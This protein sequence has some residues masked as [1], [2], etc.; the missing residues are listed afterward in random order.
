MDKFNFLDLPLIEHIKKLFPL[1][2]SITGDGLRETLGYFEK[3]NK[4]FKR[5]KFATGEKVLGWEIPKEWNIKDAYLEHIDTEKRFAEFSKSN[6]HLVGYSEPMN[7][8]ISYEELLK[9][10]H[11]LKTQPDLVPYVTSYY[12]KN[13]GFCLGE[14]T[15]NSL[16]KGDYRV[17]IDST[18]K[19]GCLDLSHAILRGKDDQELFFSSYVCH[20]SMA[21][22]E[23]SGPVLLNAIINYVK[24]TYPSN[25]YTY[26]FVMVPETIGSIAYISKYREDLKNKTICGFNLTCVGDE[27]AYSFVQTPYKDSLADVVMNSILIDK[28]NVKVYSFLNR[29]SDERQYCSPGLRLPVCTFS[30]SKFGEYPE[31]HTSADNL[32]LVTENGMQESFEVFKTI[33]DAFELGIY[34]IVNCYGEPQLGKLGLYPNLSVKSNRNA[35]NKRMDILAYCDGRRSL[36]EI[37]EIININLREI[38]NECKILNNAG[39]I[40]LS[41]NKLKDV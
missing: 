30:R 36:F 33:I 6:L 24:N 12:S 39:L 15:K 11:S 17:F 1:C 5:I 13:W 31:Y 19:D 21:N 26:R 3:F 38:V 29:G 18:L 20:P 32:N 2:R 35:V 40:R 28:K 10:I 22:N 7:K 25:F 4:E 9:K 14:K 27:R 34:P 41:R 16:P 37:S 23:L 8:I